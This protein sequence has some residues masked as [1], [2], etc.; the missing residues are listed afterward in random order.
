VSQKIWEIYGR[1]GAIEGVTKRW[2]CTAIQD[3]ACAGKPE[4]E[5]QVSLW[6]F[7]DKTCLGKKK[8]WAGVGGQEPQGVGGGWLKPIHE[9]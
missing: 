3:K 1:N 2:G 4:G 5:K 9:K 8:K 6:E 7:G